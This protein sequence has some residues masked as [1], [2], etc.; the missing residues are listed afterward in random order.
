MV[1]QSSLC[2]KDLTV[3]HFVVSSTSVR[4]ARVINWIS[5]C[6]VLCCCVFN[7]SKFIPNEKQS[8]A[9]MIFCFQLKKSDY[10]E[11][12][13][14][15]CSIAR[16]VWT[17]VS[18]FQKCWLRHKTRS[19]TR[20]TEYRH[21]I[22]RCRM[23]STVGRRWFSN[24]KTT[25]RA[26]GLCQQVVSNRLREMRNVQKTGSWVPHELNDREMKKPKNTCEMLLA[27]YKRKSFLHRI[28]TGDGKLIYFENP[29]RKK[30]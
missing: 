30:S 7:M 21:K 4:R 3:R 23:A 1:H 11:K 22:R 19:K 5:A 10:L 25:R 13:W 6:I 9:A 12:P 17:M 29:E 27:R 16:Y 24:T 26:I 2:Y 15:T 20:N 18:A 14:W 8:R 28:V